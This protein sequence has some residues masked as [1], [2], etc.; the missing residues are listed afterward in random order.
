MPDRT[1]LKIGDRIHL[2]RVPT[3]DLEQ[4]ERLVAAVKR[5]DR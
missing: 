5:L 3:G 2:L 4:R 1:T